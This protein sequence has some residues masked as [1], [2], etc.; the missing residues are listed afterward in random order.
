MSMFSE[1]SRLFVEVFNSP[2]CS[3]L[4][5]SFDDRRQKRVLPYD[6]VAARALHIVIACFRFRR[7]EV[8]FACVD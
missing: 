1:P 6:R 7:R 8:D 2:R 4:A 3:E 5:D